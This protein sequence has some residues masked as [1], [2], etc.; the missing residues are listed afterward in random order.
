MNSPARTGRHRTIRLDRLLAKVERRAGRVCAHQ[1]IG[2]LADR[3]RA[4]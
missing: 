1:H 3:I 2:Q 4:A